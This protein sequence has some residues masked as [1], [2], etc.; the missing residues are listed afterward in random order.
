MGDRIPDNAVHACLS[1][2][3]RG[4]IEFL[5]RVQGKLAW[6]CGYFDRCVGKRTARSQRKNTPR[7]SSLT[8]GNRDDIAAAP[9]QF[10]DSC[11]I[12]NGMAMARNFCDFPAGVTKPFSNSR[13]VA[14][15]PFEI[16]IRNQQPS[17][18]EC[19]SQL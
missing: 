1:I 9:C 15:R 19:S 13:K 14:W 12:G 7:E 8:H 16:M 2:D 5:H 10:A 11:G 6:R 18:R 3:L 4:T 17:R